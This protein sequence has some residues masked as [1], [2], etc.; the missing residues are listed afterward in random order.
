[1][2][3]W[4]KTSRLISIWRA[5]VLLHMCAAIGAFRIPQAVGNRNN[6]AASFKIEKKI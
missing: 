4:L 2:T 5:A 6:D 1:M 3:N